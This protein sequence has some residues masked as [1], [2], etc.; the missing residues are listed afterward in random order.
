MYYLQTEKQRKY[1]KETIRLHYERGY[2]ED[3]ISRILPIGHA[4]VSRWIAI[5]EREKG[6]VF[7]MQSD[8]K[9]QPHPALAESDVKALQSRI[10]ELEK[11]L[12][13]AE[14]KAE[15]Y[16]EMINVAEAKFKIPIRKKAGAKR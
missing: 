8:G 1:F 4:T 7:G 16:D 13:M 11:R 14:I 3:R 12:R 6:N 10:K 5:F 2:G 15:A 9:S